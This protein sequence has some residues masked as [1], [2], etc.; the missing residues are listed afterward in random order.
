MDKNPTIKAKNSVIRFLK[1][2]QPSLLKP[3]GTKPCQSPE[4]PV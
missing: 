4:Y 1:M 2:L 3:K